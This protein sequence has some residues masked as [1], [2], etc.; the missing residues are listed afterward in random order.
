MQHPTNHF[1][2]GEVF[3]IN[4]VLWTEILLGGGTPDHLRHGGAGYESKYDSIVIMKPL[5]KKH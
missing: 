1:L 5:I 4:F 3:I 2:V